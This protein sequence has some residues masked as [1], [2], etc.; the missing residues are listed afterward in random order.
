MAEIMSPKTEKLVIAV[1]FV[2]AGYHALTMF[3]TSL[4][5]IPYINNMVIGLAGAASIY[6]AYTLYAK[7]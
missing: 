6:G 7:Y 4:P 5:A 1:G 3:F 2:I